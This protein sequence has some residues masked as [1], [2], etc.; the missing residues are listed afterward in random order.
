MDETTLSLH[1]VLRACWMKRG[2]QKLVPAAG[3][4]RSHHVFGAYNWRSDEVIWTT[5]PRKNRE[6]FITFLE[7]LVQS[8]TTDRPV[9]IIL[10]NA[11]YHR[12]AASQAALSLW[13]DQ[14]LPLWLPPYCSDLNPIERFWKHLKEYACANKLY[15]S[16]EKLVTAVEQCLL[17][18]ATFDH[19][20]RFSFSKNFQ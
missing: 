12:S 3:Q 11:A 19:P 7:H 14:L 6:S 13:T 1:P 17:I 4:Q 9:V 15:P 20:D 5:A 18:Q 10:D 2:Q 8:Q 16:I